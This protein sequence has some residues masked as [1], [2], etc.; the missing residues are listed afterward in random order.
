MIKT[1]Y[2]KDEKVYYIS[3]YFFKNFFT[4]KGLLKP[5][6]LKDWIRENI[7]YGKVSNTQNI[8]DSIE[9]FDYC[10]HEWVNLSCIAK[11]EETLV[12]QVYTNI[13][14]FFKNIIGDN[15]ND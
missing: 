8:Y 6:H 3:S 7:K 5:Y 10:E 14:T 11:E 9:V 12:E 1:D 2:Q 13:I 15:N 4:F